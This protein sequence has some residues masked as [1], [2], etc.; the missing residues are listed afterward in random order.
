MNLPD[1]MLYDKDSRGGKVVIDAGEFVDALVLAG[2]INRIALFPEWSPGYKSLLPVQGKP[3][4]AYTLQ[5]LRKCARIG[6]I[7]IAGPAREL[8]N[9]ID[10]SGYDEMIEGSDTLLANLRNGLHFFRESSLV[11][12]VP[13]DLPLLT[14][15]SIID[16]LNAVPNLHRWGANV[17][18]WSMVPEQMFAGDYRHIRKGFNRFSDVSVCHGNLFLV[19][20]SI[21]DNRKFVTRMERIYNARKSTVQAAL[22]IGPVTGLSYWIGVSVLRCLTLTQFA[23]I[24]SFGFGV[25]LIPILVYDPDIA[26]DI[27]EARDYQFIIAELDRRRR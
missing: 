12:I 7:C 6:R 17:I 4:I 5:A 9:I 8:R 15:R 16:F 26:V 1:R 27:D 14:A 13:A 19:T 21:A 11:L 3:L 20:P 22:A 25:A 24:A 23:R 18:A 10:E 2:G